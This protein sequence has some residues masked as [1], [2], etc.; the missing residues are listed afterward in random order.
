L[1]RESR[2]GTNPSTSNKWRVGAFESR[3]GH[4]DEPEALDQLNG[5]IPSLELKTFSD[6]FFREIAPVEAPL[7]LGEQKV[8]HQGMELGIIFP[9]QQPTLTTLFDHRDTL[10]AKPTFQLGWREIRQ[11]RKREQLLLERLG[12]RL[13]DL[14]GEIVV[15]R[16]GEPFLYG[17]VSHAG[18]KG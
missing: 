17:C 18:S 10:I 7:K 3:F 11:E 6:R 15:E 4:L 9:C 13:K 12:D 2:N 5:T 8:P 1:C 16:C 14:L